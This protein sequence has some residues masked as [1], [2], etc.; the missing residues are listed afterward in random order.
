MLEGVL[1][2]E[3]LRPDA[4]SES[5]NSNSTGLDRQA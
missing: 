3:S 5:L 2:A 4:P 1:I